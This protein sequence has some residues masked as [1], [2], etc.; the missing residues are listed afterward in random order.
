MHQPARIMRSVA[1]VELQLMSRAVVEVVVEGP[2]D[3]VVEVGGPNFRLPQG[4]GAPGRS[5]V[6]A[7]AGEA[8]AA[9][10]QQFHYQA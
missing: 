6:G 4:L 7:Q 10:M 8:V 5:D 3:R 9:R 2:E 1:K